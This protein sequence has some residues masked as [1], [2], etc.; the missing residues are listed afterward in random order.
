MALFHEIR[1]TSWAIG[2][3]VGA[4]IYALIGD[5]AKVSGNRAPL[6]FAIASLVMLLNGYVLGGIVRRYPRA[7]SILAIV[8]ETTHPW[9]A[10]AFEFLR[11]V[12][13]GLALCVTA[14]LTVKFAYALAF[15]LVAVPP[16][17]GA[18]ATFLVA[19]AFLVHKGLDTAMDLGNVGTFVEVGGLVLVIGAAVILAPA[20]STA[21]PADLGLRDATRSI[22]QIVFAFG[23]IQGVLDMAGDVQDAETVLPRVVMLAVGITGLL[24]TSVCSAA[25]SMVGVE[26]LA[27]RSVS[28][29]GMVLEKVGFPGGTEQMLAFVSLVSVGNTCMGIFTFVSRI[30]LSLAC[31]VKGDSKV[32]PPAIYMGMVFVGAIV[33][34]F[35]D[36]FALAGRVGIMLLVTFVVVDY[37]FLAAVASSPLEKVMGM[38]ALL[39]SCGLVVVDQ[40]LY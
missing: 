40:C 25:L 11:L 20:P 13:G 31:H 8:K 16:S 17:V 6:M 30:A 38:L 26:S 37:A 23:G 1:L 18:E 21:V 28:P 15:G 7:G 19:V 9:V 12:E 24:Y 36:V 29:L 4:G 35:G 33:G 5:I 27:A 10:T 14:K 22:T 34:H 3:S 32:W 2:L 39:A